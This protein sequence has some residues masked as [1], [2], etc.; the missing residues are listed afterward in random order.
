MS[1]VAQLVKS[2]TGAKFYYLRTV[3]HD[4]PDE[5]CIAILQNLIPAMDKDSRILIDEMVLPNSGVHWQVTSVDLT[6][7][8][9]L[10]SQ[11]RTKEQWYMLLDKAGLKILKIYTYHSPLHNSVMVVVPK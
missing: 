11:E 1:H 6:M 2:T 7:M 8:A 4:Y 3:L 9:C 10:G 5:K